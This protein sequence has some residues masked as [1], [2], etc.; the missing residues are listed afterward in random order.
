MTCTVNIPANLSK[1][2]ACWT[3]QQIHAMQ[4]D[5]DTAERVQK[6]FGSSLRPLSCLRMRQ[7]DRYFNAPPEHRYY[8][9]HNSAGC[10]IQHLY[11][12]D[13]PYTA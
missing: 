9:L 5:L 12:D 7:M 1:G 3:W 13:A 4:F 6:D 2:R 11:D 10:Y 8:L